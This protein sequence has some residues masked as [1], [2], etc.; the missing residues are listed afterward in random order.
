MQTQQINNSAARYNYGV[1][2]GGQLGDNHIKKLE[3]NENKRSKIK[4]G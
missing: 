3:Q 2:N 4:A 1:A